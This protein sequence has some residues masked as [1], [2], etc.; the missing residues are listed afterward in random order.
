MIAHWKT[1]EAVYSETPATGRRQTIFH[2]SEEVL[3][4][5]LSLIISLGLLP[6]L[7]LESQ[8]L[9]KRVCSSKRR[10]C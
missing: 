6:C 3:I 5:R 1:H 2:R 4:N 9:I 7:F 10:F 8:S